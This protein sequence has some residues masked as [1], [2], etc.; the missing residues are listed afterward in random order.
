[1]TEKKTYSTVK[2]M[3]AFAR[4]QDNDI[5]GHFNW[6]IRSVNQ[7][8]LE[9]HFKLPENLRHLEPTVRERVKSKLSRGKLD[10][11]LSFENA[12]EQAGLEVNHDV[13][14]PLTAAI[15]EIQMNLPEATQVNPLEIL[16]WPGVLQ[17]QKNNQDQDVIDKALLKGFDEALSLLG[18]HRS[19]EGQALAHLINDRCHQIHQHLTLLEPKLEE[20]FNNH[21]EKLLQR[22]AGLTETIDESRYHQEVAILAQK[23]DITEELDRLKTHLDEVTLILKSQPG[24]TNNKPIGRRL[25]FLMQELNREANTLGSKSIDVQISQVSIEL[26]VLIEQMREQVQN[27]E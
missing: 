27:I 13:L 9:L 4:Y 21:S 10:I 7:R 2:S 12:H 24:N 8:Y 3:T 11:S 15:N 14:N 26:K 23:A 6:E 20:L 19:R 18:E 5:H 25:D 1:M 16:K 17:T 22:I